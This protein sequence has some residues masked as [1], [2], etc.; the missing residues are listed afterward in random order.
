VAKVMNKLFSV[1]AFKS[2][3]FADSIVEIREGIYAIILNR[4]KKR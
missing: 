2:G 4:L 3:I 1:S